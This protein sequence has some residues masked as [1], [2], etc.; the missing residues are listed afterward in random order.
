MKNAMPISTAEFI[1]SVREDI[2]D[3]TYH[4]K[5]EEKLSRY[6]PPTFGPLTKTEAMLKNAK[7]VMAGAK[8][9]REYVDEEIKHVK[10]FVFGS[11]KRKREKDMEQVHDLVRSMPHVDRKK[12]VQT[13]AKDYPETSHECVSDSD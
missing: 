12:T 3:G 2:R 13:L 11:K 7:F 1:K 8:K 9:M 5:F 6:E 10:S 4:D